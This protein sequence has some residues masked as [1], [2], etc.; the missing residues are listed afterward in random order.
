MDGYGEII[1]LSCCFCN[2]F[3]DLIEYFASQPKIPIRKRIS[4]HTKKVD[5]PHGK[6]TH[7]RVKM[8]RYELH[9]TNNS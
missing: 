7:H 9:F 2:S 3:I 8:Y 6:P 1:F 5:L 4:Q